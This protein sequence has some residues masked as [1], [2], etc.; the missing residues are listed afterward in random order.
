M[1]LGAM[2]LT[3]STTALREGRITSRELVDACLARIAEHDE[4]IQAWTFLDADHARAQADRLDGHRRA[5]RS[6]GPLHGVPIGVKDIIDTVDMPTEC[7][8]P[9]YR[10]RRPKR[11]AT[12]TVKLR[13][14]GAVILGKT[15]TTEFA[16]FTPGKTANPHDPT[17]TPGGSSSGSAAAVAS[18]MVPGALGSQTA[19]SVIRPAAFCGIYGFK[20][21]FGRI[22]RHGVLCQSPALDHLGTFARSLEDIAILTEVLCGYDPQDSATAPPQAR[23]H[24]PGVM[25]EEPPVAPRIAFAKTAAWE[26]ADADMQ[27]AVLELRD[28]LGDRCDE[29]DL[30]ES[31]AGALDGQKTLMTA[32]IAKNFAAAQARGEDQISARFNEMIEQGRNV[33]A[34]TYNNTIEL[35]ETLNDLLD[36]YFDSY[37]AV[38][39]PSAT[40]E[41]PSGLGATGNPV[42]GS[43]WT[44]LGVPAVTLPL[45]QGSNGMPMG[46]Q[47]IGQKGDDARLLRTARWLEQ[48]VNED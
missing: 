5:G 12:A 24:L 33:S 41:A 46:A 16:A 32:D 28:A 13:E 17:R 7:G 37:D 2:G 21:T 44:F 45:F 26:H 14:A 31:F 30:P 36:E 3:E 22:S 18:F 34:V 19:S 20:P 25:A 42:F 35:Q 4:S 10:G 27:D 1:S 6:L 11:D 48:Q 43:T 29:I 40:G 8:S 15:V 9:L 47:L 38:L 23:P 39:T